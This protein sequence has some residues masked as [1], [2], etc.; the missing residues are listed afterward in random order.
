MPRA[1]DAEANAA[2]KAIGQ[3]ARNGEDVGAAK[4]AAKAIGD[5]ARDLDKQR[6][7]AE[8]ALSATLAELP[9]IC[10]PEV[11]VGADESGNVIISSW[12]EVSKRDHDL[13][14]W[15]IGAELNILDLERGAKLGGSGFAVLRGPGAQL[16]RGLAQFF[17]T[18]L[19]K[20]G[21]T[22]LSVPYL[23]RPDI[24]YGT[25][26]LP[27]FADQLYAC[28]D[29]EL[30]LIPTAEVPVTNLHANE[31]IDA[32]DLPMRYCAHTPCFRR[33]AGAAGVGTR[34]ITPGTPIR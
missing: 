2:S 12:G 10:L 11:P 22:E 34:G 18:H 9:N 3:A 15:D 30:L 6:A 25:G 26:Q 13:P 1:S 7:D 21:H 29:D 31:I 33:E 20:N 23:V 19:T 28:P 17:L 8:A 4:A 32:E 5:E 24:M 16:Q 27:K 14:H